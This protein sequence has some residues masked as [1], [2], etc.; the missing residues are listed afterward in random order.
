MIIDAKNAVAG[1]LAS[2]VAKKLLTGE[3]II[4]INAE[5]AIITGNPNSIKNRYLELKRKGTPFHGPFLPKKPDLFLK[6]IIRGMLPYKK[7][8]GRNAMK[9][10]R[11]YIGF[12]K[13]LEAKHI[14]VVEQSS[15]EIKS[16]YITIAVLSKTLGWN[17]A[18]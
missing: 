1:R 11:V 9:R 17:P 5:Q 14:M 2:A 18:A 3:K 4:I 16:N 10:L 7:P 13:S 15:K 8:K 6:R 12:P